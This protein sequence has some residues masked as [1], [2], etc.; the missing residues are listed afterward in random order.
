M[1]QWAHILIAEVPSGSKSARGSFGNGTAVGMLAA[2]SRIK[3]LIQVNPIEVKKAITGRKTASK[4]EMIAWAVRTWPDA[5]WKRHKSKGVIMLT[6]SN[7]HIADACGIVVA[8]IKTAEFRSAAMMTSSIMHAQD[9]C[10]PTL[11]MP[12]PA[13]LRLVGEVKH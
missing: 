1:V 6:D 9:E 3:P 13:T 12:T 7:E 5:R 2:L 4:D 11:T 10:S 8:G